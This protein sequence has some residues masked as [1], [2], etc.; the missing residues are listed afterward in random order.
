M[1]TKVIVVPNKGAKYSKIVDTLTNS[2][3][4]VNAYII[5]NRDV[6]DADELVLYEDCRE[7]LIEILAQFVNTGVIV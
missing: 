2:L 1:D 7:N 4:A 6:L 5:T 3:R